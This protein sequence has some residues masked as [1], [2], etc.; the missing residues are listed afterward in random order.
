VEICE[1]TFDVGAW[2]R[3]VVY[4]RPRSVAAYRGICYCEYDV[5]ED[6]PVQHST[7]AGVSFI[8]A[9]NTSVGFDISDVACEAFVIFCFNDVVGVA[10]EVYFVCVVCVSEGAKGIVAQ[11]VNVEGA[12]G[13]DLEERCIFVQVYG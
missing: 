7:C 9:G 4:V 6:F 11:C 10:E 3:G 5:R 1:V 2:V 12:V 8:V 13:E